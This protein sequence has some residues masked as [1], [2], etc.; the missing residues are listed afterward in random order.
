MSPLWKSKAEATGHAPVAVSGSTRGLSAVGAYEFGMPTMSH[1]ALVPVSRRVLNSSLTRFQK[2]SS[3]PW[4]PFRSNPSERYDHDGC[5]L[6]PRQ[7]LN[8]QSPASKAGALS[9]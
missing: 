9:G 8:L 1:Y 2:G 7:D 3:G 5:T 6:R 4:S